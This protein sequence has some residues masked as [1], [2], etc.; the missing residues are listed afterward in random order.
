MS[1]ALRSIAFGAELIHP[2]V[3]HDPRRLQSLHAEMFGN[4]DCAY[5]DFKLVNG[6]AM[7]SNA[8]SG[9]PGTPVSSLT[10]LPDRIQV[11]EEQTGAGSD[12][13]RRR[14]DAIARSALSNLPMN[15]LLVQQYVVRSVVNPDS[16]DDARAFMVRG[17]FGFDEDELAPLVDTPTLAGLRLAFPPRGGDAGI[18][19]VRLESFSQDNRSLF[20]EAVGTFSRPIQRDDVDPVGERFG[21]TYAFLEERLLAFV[22]HFDVE[23]DT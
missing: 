4:A 6:G 11:R 13:F 16:T 3:K 18:F 21:A 15:V 1:H 9:M 23:Q 7:L 8:F 17:V 22:Q 19:N 12:D 5:R 20:L 10:L 14:I 2:P